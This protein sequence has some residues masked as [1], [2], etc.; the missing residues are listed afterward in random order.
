MFGNHEIWACI[1]HPGMYFLER[2]GY[3]SMSTE[4]ICCW[5]I[6]NLHSPLKFL[7]PGKELY[8]YL[9]CVSWPRKWST[10]P[11]H[12]RFLTHLWPAEKCTFQPHLGILPSDWDQP[13]R[14]P[15][16]H[17]LWSNMFDQPTSRLT[18][19]PISCVRPTVMCVSWVWWIVLY[20]RSSI[21]SRPMRRWAKLFTEHR[22]RQ[23]KHDR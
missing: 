8:N 14:A 16:Y 23:S 22:G 1:S 13:K 6:G 19:P 9:S 11:K 12:F 10:W 21:H 2:L 18:D 15:H 7:R 5:H 4:T 20:M 17:G 3:W